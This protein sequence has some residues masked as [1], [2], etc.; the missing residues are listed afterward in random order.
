[1][2][3]SFLSARMISFCQSSVVE[4]L[5]RQQETDH[6]LGDEELKQLKVSVAPLQ[7]CNVAVM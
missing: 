7:S 4:R 1:M 2:N 6:C 3:L 5:N